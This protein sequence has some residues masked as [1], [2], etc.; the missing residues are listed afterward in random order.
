[1]RKKCSIFLFCLC[2]LMTGCG[3]TEKGGSSE[4]SQVEEAD[5][6][7][8]AADADTEED[9]ATEEVDTGTEESNKV[10]DEVDKATKEED[11]ITEAA[12]AVTEKDKAAV[13][14]MEEEEPETEI[15]EKDLFDKVYDKYYSPWSEDE[16]I[17]AINERS[18]YRES[19]SFYSE[20]SDYMENVREV[21]DI[22]N[23]IEP[24]YYTD[25]KYYES[26]DFEKDPLLIIHLAKNEIYA[27]HGYI[28]NDEDLNNYFMVQLWYEPSCTPEDF[29]DSVFNDYEKANLKL[30]AELDTYK[31]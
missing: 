13:K 7:I 11:K 18:Q 26:Q 9:K 22:S 16:M 15:S 29:D 28:F 21:R 8:E 4:V 2:L 20:V 14:A 31:E 24:L 1:M 10:T 3:K 12:D 27:R 5:K 30:L 17:V 25:M 19:C 23:M 6:V